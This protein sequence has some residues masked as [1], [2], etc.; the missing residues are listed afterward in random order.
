V[1]D[2]LGRDGGAAGG[3]RTPPLLPVAHS[4]TTTAMDVIV[5]TAIVLLS[6]CALALVLFALGQR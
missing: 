5:A 2:L 3:R 1:S 6:L 4:H